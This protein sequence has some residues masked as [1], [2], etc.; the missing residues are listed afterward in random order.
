[1]KCPGNL[2]LKQA[3]LSFLCTRITQLEQTPSEDQRPTFCDSFGQI[4]QKR[5]ASVALFPGKPSCVWK[6][7]KSPGTPTYN[8][9]HVP[10][11]MAECLEEHLALDAFS[12]H[13]QFPLAAVLC[14]L[15]L[16]LLCD[17]EVH[18]SFSV[19]YFA[20]PRIIQWSLPLEKNKHLYLQYL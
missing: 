9:C 16:R 13:W 6:L 11:G 17:F 10:V 15:F 4:Y 14:V 20:P 18:W 1:M 2:H 12:H 8:V 5:K 3:S 7:F 19:F